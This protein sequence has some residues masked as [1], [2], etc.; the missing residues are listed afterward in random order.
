MYRGEVGG[1]HAAR[2]SVEASTLH[3]V[4]SWIAP[5]M[6]GTLM[7]TMNGSDPIFR[8]PKL[9]RRLARSWDAP[10]LAGEII[11]EWST[12]LRCALGRAYPERNLI[13][14]S[15]LLKDA[16]YAP[17]FDEVVCHEAAHLAVFLIYGSKAASHGPEWEELVRRA[18]YDPRVSHETDSLANAPND[19]CVRY[20]H[21][22]PVCQTKRTANHPQPKWRCVACQ[23]A[24]LVGALVI[25]SRPQSTEVLDA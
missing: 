12:R 19:A 11:C 15:L 22:C 3:G 14:F 1:E 20:E 5:L 17:Y 18:G 2:R 21:V 24:G 7:A 13:R 4:Q 6:P 25:Q 23:N 10:E 9:L 16:K 8:C